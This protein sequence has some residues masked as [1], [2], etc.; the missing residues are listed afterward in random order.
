MK[1]N[2]ENEKNIY[3]IEFLKKMKKWKKI[4]SIFNYIYNNYKN[5]I[6]NYILWEL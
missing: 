5:I 4:N 3:F 1:M 2:Y 6:Y